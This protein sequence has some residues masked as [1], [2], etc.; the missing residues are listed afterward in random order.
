MPSTS[1]NNGKDSFNELEL[2]DTKLKILKRYT[3][4]K[5]IGSGAQG[6]VLYAFLDIL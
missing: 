6:L 1:S 4:V 5:V 2:N 3:N